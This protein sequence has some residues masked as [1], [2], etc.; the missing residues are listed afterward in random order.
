MIETDAAPCT[1][2]RPR[3]SLALTGVAL[4]WTVIAWVGFGRAHQPEPLIHGPGV[5]ATHRLSE[6]QPNLAGTP[7]DTEVLTFD[8]GEEGARVLVICGTHPNEPASIVTGA[9]LT[10]NAQCD[11]G[12][13]WVIPRANASGYTHGDPQE[14]YLQR[15]EIALPDGSR[16]WFRH[17]S[18]YT[19]P[20]HQW[21]DPTLHI[22]PAGQVLAGIDSRN[23]NRCYPGR[24]EGMLTERVAWA[25]AE[26]V[27]RERIDLVVDIH[28]AAPEYPTINVMVY[29]ERAADLAATTQIMLEDAVPGF[30]IT[31][32]PSPLNL[33]GLSHREMGDHTDAQ[34][35]LLESANP[36]Q[37]RLKGATCESQ[38]LVGDDAAY[39]AAFRM[40]RR[41]QESDSAESNR[42]LVWAPPYDEEAGTYPLRVRVARH[43]AVVME[44]MVWLESERG[45]IVVE[46]IP[47]YEEIV[48]QGLGAFL[49][50]STGM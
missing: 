39:A 21:P 37:G 33:R 17:G 15:F 1:I 29:H 35:V 41:F 16:R 38:I 46:G 43:L 42:R 50:P 34:V 24:P 45:A 25:I 13:L 8:S 4:L 19:N 22:N 20:I 31:G 47:S 44:L 49:L 18:R 11:T 14:A 23:L 3:V 6:W 27:R 48:T 9:L 28:E 26:M 12:Q 30:Q 40:Q 36:S 5:T 10:E 7:A 32:E 2:S